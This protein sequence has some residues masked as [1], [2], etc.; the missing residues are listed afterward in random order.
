MKRLISILVM[1]AA[2]VLFPV[3]TFAIDYSITNTQIQAD[4]QKNGD[5]NVKETHTYKFDDDFNG[6]TRELIAK[7]GTEISN[8]KAYENGKPLKTEKDENTYKIHRA[9][10]YETIS[11][12]LHYSIKNGVS[13][14][15]DAAEL[16]WSF[17]DNNNESTYENLTVTVHPPEKTT[18]DVIAFGYDEAFNKEAIQPNG[19]VKFSFGDVPDGTNG[20]IRV[21]YDNKLFSAASNMSNKPMKEKILAAEQEGIDQAAEDARM[22]EQ[23][24]TIGEVLIPA[25][26]L[27]ILAILLYSWKRSRDLKLMLEKEE[28][29]TSNKIPEE[30][31]SIPATISYTNKG[32]FSSDTVAAGLMDLLRKGYIENISDDQF[33]IITR[34]GALRHE[35]I[36]MEWLFDKIG[37]NGTFS[38][39]DL[40]RY[41]KQKK[42]HN[43]Y[44]SNQTKWQYAVKN[45]IKDQAFYEKN[46]IYRST[47][48][49]SSLILLPFLFLFPLYDLF[50]LFFLSLPIFLFLIG[51]AIF[52]RPK[53]EKGAATFYKWN[54]F[55]NNFPY[56]S[57]NEWSTW[58]EDERL[59][60]FIYG[61]GIKN[62]SLYKKHEELENAFQRSSNRASSNDFQPSFYSIDITTLMI[63]TAS[64]SP[65]FHS[66]GL[67]ASSTAAS[68]SNTGGG[69][70]GGGGGVGGGGGGSGAF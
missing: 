27:V 51:Y 32:A 47:V 21:A 53:S 15:S 24:S 8:F 11:V 69:F 9:G 60:S 26:G 36:L 50:S 14:Y 55:K 19:S 33:R 7:K 57:E 10:S 48:G 39:D 1:S 3:L 30:I 58:T 6:I 35:E 44:L 28:A 18:E 29:A 59:R 20:G 62:N 22:K 68:S 31:M 64:I 66:A 54:R 12:D 5:V 61:M 13:V 42:N 38:L 67:A 37:K 63:L 16:Y 4:L 41:T 70:S 25:F 45:E 65:S 46:T 23:L 2:L 40:A 43:K 52:Y 34:K 56:L 17:F 49:L